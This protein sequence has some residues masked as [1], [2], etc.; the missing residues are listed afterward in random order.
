MINMSRHVSRMAR[1]IV[2]A[3]TGN[4]LAQDSV[5]V[6]DASAG[7]SMVGGPLG[8][9]AVAGP[10]TTASAGAMSASG[11]TP[12]PGTLFGP[13][14]TPEPGATPASGTTPVP[15]T[16]FGPGATPA[17]HATPGTGESLGPVHAEDANQGAT[18]AIPSM[19]ALC[20]RAAGEGCVLL[21]NDGT[22]PLSPE[23]PVA[24][25]GRHQFDWVHTGNGSGGDVN[26]PYLA[27]LINGLDNV[28]ARYDHVL[29]ETYR[30]WCT[31]DHHAADPGFWG[32]WP[33]SLPEMP[34][35]DK[36]ARAAAADSQTAIVVIGRAAGEDQD[37]APE[38][39]GYYLSDEE[40]ELLSTVTNAFER[41]VVVLD[42][43]NMVDLSWMNL[44]EES[45]VAVLVAWAGGME[46]GNAVADVLYGRI[47][48][49]GRLT[50]AV[51][52]SLD[53]HPSSSS[54][55]ERRV[56][57]YDEGVFVGHRHFSTYA[58]REMRYPLGWGLSYTSFSY[59]PL[60]CERHEDLAYVRVRVT[61]TGERAGRDAVVLWCEAPRALIEKPLLVVASF[62]KTTLLEPGEHEVLEFTVILRD[63]AV[64]DKS[65]RAFV[66]EL[67]TY[68]FRANNTLVGKMTLGSDVVFEQLEPVCTDEVDL[69]ERIERGLAAV[70][71]SDGASDSWN[72]GALRN[73]GA[74]QSPD[75]HDPH[76]HATPQWLVDQMS[77]AELEALTRGAGTMNSPLGPGGNAGAFGGITPALQ[78]RGIGAIICA[79]GPSGAR[80]AQYA[81]LLPCATALASTWDTGLVEELYALEG[82][83]VVRMGVDVLLAPGMNLQRSPLCGRNFEY[84]SED[85]LLCGRMATAVVRGLRSANVEACPK[86]FACNNQERSR[87]TLDVRVDERTLR[88]VYLRPFEMCVRDARPRLIMTSYN[89]VNGVWS[90]YNYDL[91]TTVLREEWGFEGVII[92]DW[93]MRRAKSPEFPL[94]RDNAYRVR[95]GV[96]VLMPGNMGH[97]ARG[98]RVH[99]SLL[100]SLDKPHGITRAELE[101]TARRV[102]A[103]VA[104]R[105]ADKRTADERN[106]PG[107]P[108]I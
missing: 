21:E 5:R 99:P 34:V 48:P 88:E 104:Q 42:V 28:G 103:L 85:P 63:I 44:Y 12:V 56:Q 39:G 89:K 74:P 66:L 64:F 55:G 40:H 67:G 46:A 51:A 80:L 92:T 75:A 79:D 25:F 52:R 10:G 1:A 50:S 9:G 38:P 22:L 23:Q 94:L 72:P 101:R 57:R 70:V 54:F 105:D 69:R 20:R 35:S 78:K 95:A 18:S 106:A 24:I 37:L 11:T 15:G 102:L 76:A 96:D 62:G 16:L 36:L 86:H 65:R 4:R 47:N 90:H 13:G 3:V 32:H 87:S 26:A 2:D 53:E 19:A 49:S 17:P 14:A 91:A 83:E 59:E 100:E 58:P 97:L 7:G 31:D 27:N 98:Y 108:Y 73:P 6:S 33:Q 61:N 68:C 30:S 93:W 29:A 77:D 41:T 84:F 60:A 8:N 45:I 81:S 71:S 43:C 107:I 82:A